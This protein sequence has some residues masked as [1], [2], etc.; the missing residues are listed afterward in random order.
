MDDNSGGG[1][2]AKLRK[3]ITR[4]DN[5]LLIVRPRNFLSAGTTDIFQNG[6]LLR[7]QVKVEGWY[8]FLLSLQAK[9][10]ISVLPGPQGAPVHMMYLISEDGLHIEQRRRGAPRSQWEAPE[11]IF[12]ARTMLIGV[13]RP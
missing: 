2:S 4:T 9:E 5:Y 1:K 7:R 12:G 3:L 10:Q 6:V 13:R 11:G 8:V